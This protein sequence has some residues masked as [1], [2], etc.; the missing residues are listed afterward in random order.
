M[1]VRKPFLKRL[2]TYLRLLILPVPVVV[3]L[4]ALAPQL[5][6]PRQK[7]SKRTIK[8]RE[9]RTGLSKRET[10]ACARLKEG[11]N[12]VWERLVLTNLLLV[13]P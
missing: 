1:N 12:S 5:N 7:M 9:S 13:V 8:R 3:R 11:V 10:A 6:E 2:E 4:L